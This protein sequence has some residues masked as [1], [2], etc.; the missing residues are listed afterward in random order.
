MPVTGLAAMDRL[1][2]RLAALKP[3]AADV[4]LP[5]ATSVAAQL[6]RDLLRLDPRG[7]TMMRIIT[8]GSK[9]RISG[10]RAPVGL[11]TTRATRRGTT[12]RIDLKGMLRGRIRSATPALKTAVRDAAKTGLKP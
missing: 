1:S 8:E 5:T 7:R 2:A 3:P 12:V 11:R 9:V 10:R 4:M 6:E